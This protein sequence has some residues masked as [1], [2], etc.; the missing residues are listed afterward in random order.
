M[1]N[2]EDRFVD[3]W[4][5]IQ[6]CDPAI[7]VVVCGSSRH[8][9]DQRAPDKEGVWVD[10]IATNDLLGGRS[11]LQNRPFLG[12]P[13]HIELN[14]ERAFRHILA[15]RRRQLAVPIKER[16]RFQVDWKALGEAV[17]GKRILDKVNRVRRLDVHGFA[18][19]YFD[20]SGF[21]AL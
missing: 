13:L 7:V 21:H 6:L 8:C 4:G 5:K 12:V 14:F 15:F 10:E 18:I 16:K 17:N 9:S 11:F 19:R 1:N 2:R 20:Q 3:L